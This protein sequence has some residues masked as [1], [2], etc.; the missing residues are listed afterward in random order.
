MVRTFPERTSFVRNCS[1]RAPGKVPNANINRSPTAYLYNSAEERAQYA[2]GNTD[3]TM[4]MLKFLSD[5]PTP[6]PLGMVRG[7]QPPSRNPGHGRP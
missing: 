7:A 6:S 4:A 2:D 3:K 1:A 5:E